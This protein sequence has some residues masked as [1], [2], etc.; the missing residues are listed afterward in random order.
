VEQTHGRAPLLVAAGRRPPTR[1]RR[2]ATSEE[3][4]LSGAAAV[5]VAASFPCRTAVEPR[6]ARAWAVLL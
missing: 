3:G 1:I 6:S 2:A 5:A 4:S